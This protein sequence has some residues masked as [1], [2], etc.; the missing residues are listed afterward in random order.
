MTIKVSLPS[1]A[2]PS[3][4]RSRARARCSSRSCASNLR[5][6]G[7]HVGCD[8]RSA[9]RAPCIVD[10]QA[11]KTCNMLA[12]Q[13]EGAE[14]TTIEGIAQADGALHPMQAAFKRVPRPAVRLLH[15]RHG[16]E[17]DRPGAAPP[18]RRASKPIRE[19]LDGNL[20][21]CT[22]YQNIVKAVQT[23]AAAM[24]QGLRSTPWA[25]R[26]PAF[27]GESRRAQGRRALPHRPRP[28]HRRHHPAAA[29]R[30]A[31]LRALAAR[32]RQAAQGRHRRR[33]KA[34]GVL[35]IFTGER[36]QGRRRAA[37]RLA[38]QQHRR[39]AD[40]GAEAPGARRRQGALRR[41]P[42]RDGRRRDLRAGARPRRR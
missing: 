21:R 17:R 30:Y 16:D 23:G 10:G 29:R 13:A 8:T 12:M 41:R 4:S 38:D 40:E 26:P 2:R 15:A 6:T 20:C 27:I 36:L 14:I 22:G 1:T 33:A 39:H 24:A 35:G 5:L 28:V 11:M 32:A 18:E 25:H 3:R 42:R 31:V 19:R 37:L 9:A 34:P 7:T